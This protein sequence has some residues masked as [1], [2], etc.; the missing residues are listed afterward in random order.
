MKT[1]SPRAWKAY[2]YT[3]E[4]Y[5]ELNGKSYEDTAGKDNIMREAYTEKV[6]GMILDNAKVVEQIYTGEEI[7]ILCVAIQGE[8]RFS[9]GFSFS[10]IEICSKIALRD[11]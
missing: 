8:F 11:I 4:T 5:K 10:M 3:E 9:S 6:L 1:S 2:G 7:A